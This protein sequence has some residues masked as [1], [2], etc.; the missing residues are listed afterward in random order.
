MLIRNGLDIVI[1]HELPG[2][3]GRMLL[4]KALINDT[5]YLLVN[6][7]GPNKDAD[8]VKFFQYL[9]TTLREMDLKSDDNVIIGGDFNCPLDPTK[10]KK[11]DILIPRQHLVN[12][13][14]NI[15]GLHDIW[16]SKNP[17]TLSFTLSKSSPFMFCRLDYW[18][19]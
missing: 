10:D 9:S 3:N 19:I 7:Y 16:R 8:A 13:V 6:V 2:S 17:T 14:E 12:S 11:G 4:L 1:Q 18:L 5:N 15:F